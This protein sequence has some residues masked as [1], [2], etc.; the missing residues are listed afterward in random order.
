MKKLT[1]KRQSKR[2]LACNALLPVF[3]TITA[4]PPLLKPSLLS[5]EPSTAPRG[6][7]PHAAHRAH[8]QQSKPTQQ[9]TAR[10]FPP[11]PTSTSKAQQW[12]VGEGF[13][14][15][16][17]STAKS[18]PALHVPAQERCGTLTPLL[19]PPQ[20]PAAGR[21]VREENQELVHS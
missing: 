17:A 4:T 10:P 21:R 6:A 20:E 12:V 5:T 19:D 11:H 15:G 3:V 7:Q 9:Q 13:G 14:P 18:I 2:C 1:T 8:T 16:R